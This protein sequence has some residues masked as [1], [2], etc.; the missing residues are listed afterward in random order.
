[1]LV[2]SCTHLQFHN[3]YIYIQEILFHC[4]SIHQIFILHTV[5]SSISSSI[6]CGHRARWSIWDPLFK[7]NLSSFPLIFWL[8]PFVFE[9]SE[10]L[11]H[12]IKGHSNFDL[13]PFWM[14]ITLMAHTT[15][16]SI[17]VILRHNAFCKSKY[18]IGLYEWL[19]VTMN[20]SISLPSVRGSKQQCPICQHRTVLQEKAIILLLI[21]FR[22]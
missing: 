17:M 7:C 13:W 16:S 1:M 9:T 19:C 18:N 12:S 22:V 2:V 10:S 15:A 8:V 5:L 3:F 4:A 14:T 11:T 21:G 20:M 6:L